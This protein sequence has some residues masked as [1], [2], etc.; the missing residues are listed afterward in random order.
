MR[1]IA[2]A[3]V[4][5]S[6]ALSAAACEAQTASSKPPVVPASQRT[7]A[8]AGKPPSPAPKLPL[9]TRAQMKLKDM[10][11]YNGA[12]TGKRDDATVAAIKKFQSSK[13]L[14][15]SGRLTPETIK[16]LGV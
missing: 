4:A 11:Q 1:R 2:I 3:I 14:P 16:A 9:Y 8:N 12:V 15:V 10:G 6:C 5:L 7:Q 13:N